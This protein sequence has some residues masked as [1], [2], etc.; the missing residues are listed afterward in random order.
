[1]CYHCDTHTGKDRNVLSEIGK[2]NNI[3]LRVAGAVM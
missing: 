2:I 3:R 1:M